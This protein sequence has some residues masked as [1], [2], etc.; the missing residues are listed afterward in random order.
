MEINLKAEDSRRI[1]ESLR[2]GVPSRLIG[3]FFSSSR[4]NL[5]DK[6]DRELDT[7]ISSSKS[8]GRIITGKYGEGKTHLLNTVFSMAEKRDMVVTL[9]PLSKETPFNNIPILYKKMI[10]NTYLPGY[11][12][13]DIFR[14]MEKI[15]ANSEK[16]RDFLSFAQNSLNTDRLYFVLKAYL[17]SRDSDDHFILQ[18]DLAGDTAPASLIRSFYSKYCH[19]TMK[20]RTRFIKSRDILDY[21]RFMSHMFRVLGYSGWVVLFDES[22]LIGRLGKQSRMKAYRHINYFL[23][24]GPQ[25]ESVYSLFAFTSSFAED[26][27]QGKHDMDNARLLPDDEPARKEI[28]TALTEIENAQEL[29]ALSDTELAKLMENI[30]S[31]YETA[32]SWKCP[33]ERDQIIRKCIKIGFLLRTKIRATIEYLDELYLYGKAAENIQ[34]SEVL[35]GEDLSHED[36]SLEGLF[37]QI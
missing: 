11:V 19:E 30:I 21:F 22:E 7:T 33:V 10:E 17:N 25:T 36:V 4:R 13:P 29:K 2:S 26:V 27:I 3:S 20:S 15:S 1:I 28:I 37:D 32:F 6:I 24:P 14:E 12:T 16:G 34:A 31:V 35:M 23:N 18:S 9:L 8:R 5:L